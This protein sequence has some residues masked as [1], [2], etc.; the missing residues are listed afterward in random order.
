MPPTA[1]P[2]PTNLFPVWCERLARAYPRPGGFVETNLN[3]LQLAFAYDRLLTIIGS[4]TV[5]DPIELSFLNGT[6]PPSLLRTLWFSRSRRATDSG[7]RA[8]PE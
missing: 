4:D 5:V 7:V 3:V 1:E 8:A 2:S 6:F